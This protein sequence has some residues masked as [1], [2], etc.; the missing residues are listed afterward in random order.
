MQSITMVVRSVNYRT[1]VSHDHIDKGV[2]SWTTVHVQ[3]VDEET[4]SSEQEAGD[5]RDTIVDSF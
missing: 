4:R 1:T 2:V 3:E 5:G